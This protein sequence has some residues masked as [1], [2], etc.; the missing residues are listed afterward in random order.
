MQL[1]R[2]YAIELPIGTIED[3][4]D[5]PVRGVMLDVSRDKVPTMATLFGLIDLL[6]ELKINQLQ[7]Y[8]EHTFAYSKHRDVWRDASPMTAEEVRQLDKYCRARFIELVPNQNSFGHM[9]RWL[10]HPRYESLAEKPEG[11]TFPWGTHHPGGFSLNPLDPRSLELVEGL[12]DELLPNFTSRLFNVG[13]DETFDLGLGKSKLECERR[14]KERYLEFLLKIYDALKR[15]GRT[16]QFWGDIILHKP[17][18]ISELPKDVIALNWGYEF[19][20]PFDTEAAAFAN[21][22]VPFYVCPGTSSW[23]SI[24]G[25]TDVALGNLKNAAQNGLKHGAAGYLNTDWGDYGHL[26]YLPISYLGLA[27]GA[28]CSWCYETTRDASIAEALDLHIFRDAA[29]VMG[30]LMHDFGNVYQ[31][32]RERL[33]MSSRLFWTL[34]GGEDRLRLFKDVTVEEYDAAEARINAALAPLDRA[35]MDRPDAQ[36]I[37]DEVRNAAAMLRYAC[38]RGRRRLRENRLPGHNDPAAQ[39]IVKEHRRLWLA[40]NRPGGLNSSVAHLTGASSTTF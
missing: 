40:R 22:G 5:F 15:R 14:G 13:C 16:M 4:P 36:L 25:R 26:Q 7:L 12:Y 19:D 1:R 24:S 37:R 28:A 34:V 27:A 29:G 31:G 9:E 21:A 10:K 33:K 3:W 2:Q 11:F 32:I 8:T 6:A 38:E 23:L 30:K 20:H 18:L 35:Q 17:E 39:S